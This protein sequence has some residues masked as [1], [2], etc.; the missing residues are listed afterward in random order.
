MRIGQGSS[1]FRGEGNP[2][3]Y[4]QLIKLMILCIK[5]TL[6]IVLTITI[7]FSQSMI[8]ILSHYWLL[9]A[10]RNT[11]SLMTLST[12]SSY[13]CIWYF[14][15]L[16][17]KNIKLWK[18]SNISQIVL[19]RCYKECQLSCLKKE[20]ILYYKMRQPFNNKMIRILL[21]NGAKLLTNVTGTT[22]QSTYLIRNILSVS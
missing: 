11:V 6:K 18:L 19:K 20:A 3:R 2:L 4:E 10:Q 17:I 8:H 15:L 5:Y 7:C 16:V 22:K 1:L 13:R 12:S 14:H 9:K 21:Q